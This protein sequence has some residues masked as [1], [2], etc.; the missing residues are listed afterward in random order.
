MLQKSNTHTG[1]NIDFDFGDTI[2]P[3]P[4]TTTFPVQVEGFETP[5]IRA[6]PLETIIAE[7]ID[8]ILDRMELSS[9]MKDYFD[10]NFI[11]QNFDFDGSV[12]Q[13]AI[14][15]TFKNRF[16]NYNMERFMKIRLFQNDSSMNTKWHAF[17]KKAK[18]PEASFQDVIANLQQFL[19]MP[20]VAFFSEQDFTKKWNCKE[21]E[22][23]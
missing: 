17:L 12:L 14:T 16:R 4:K 6:Y 8:A 7:K 23:Q 2:I 18:L 22:W 5:I 19:E 20:M 11:L 3:S 10:I 9:R 1:I 15:K 21:G 13:E